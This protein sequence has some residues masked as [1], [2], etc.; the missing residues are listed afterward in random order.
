VWESTQADNVLSIYFSVVAEKHFFSLLWFPHLISFFN[1]SACFIVLFV[2][3]CMFVL[4][5]QIL[6]SSRFPWTRFLLE[7]IEHPKVSLVYRLP[8]WAWKGCTLH[9]LLDTRKEGHDW[10]DQ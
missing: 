7:G 2:P 5:A 4:G 8:K 1:L 3:V 6:K 10:H 9:E